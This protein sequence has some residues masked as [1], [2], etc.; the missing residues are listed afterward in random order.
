MGSI[1]KRGNTWSVRYCINGDR[2]DESTHSTRRSDAITIL[3][4]REGDIARGLPVTPKVT[5]LRFSEAAQDV[6]NDHRVNGKRSTDEVERRIRL[7]LTPWFGGRRM[8]QISTAEVRAYVAHRQEQTIVVRKPRTTHFNG[9]VVETPAVLR[10]VSN[11]EINREL[12][13]LKRAFNLAV[14]AGKLLHKPHIPM[15]REAPARQGFFEPEQFMAVQRHLPAELRPVVEF[16]YITGWRVPCEVLPLEWRNVDFAGGEVRLDAGTTKN[17][18]GR[19]FPMTDD[20]RALLEERRRA[21]KAAQETCGTIIAHVFFRMVAKGRGGT[22]RPVPVR[23]I[24]KAWKAACFAA[25]CPG[26]IPHDLRRTAVRNMVR[27]GVTERV[28]MKLT[29]HKTRSVFDRY[30]I[31]NDGDLRLAAARLAGLTR[32]PPQNEELGLRPAASDV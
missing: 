31:V 21:S 15:L 20:L 32:M 4:L 9:H 14:Q 18:E 12:T 6:V 29:G 1:R 25:G 10:R 3:K 8:S 11:G 26:R 16:A 28:A 17:G 13:V 27:R 7:H 22:K 5:Q 19:V 23:A 24:Q 30:D 2:H